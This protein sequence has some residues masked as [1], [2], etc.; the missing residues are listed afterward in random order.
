[1]QGQISEDDLVESDL[2]TV[3]EEGYTLVMLAAR[4]DRLLNHYTIHGQGCDCLA[5]LLT[6]LKLKWEPVLLMEE[7]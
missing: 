1:L 6:L 2:C 7:N 3:D 4:H 5:Q